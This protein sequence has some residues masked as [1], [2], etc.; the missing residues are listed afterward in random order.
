[1]WFIDVGMHHVISHGLSF[2]L[3]QHVIHPL[4]SLHLVG[5]HEDVGNEVETGGFPLLPAT[6]E[7]AQIDQFCR[8]VK[9]VLP[10]SVVHLECLQV[11]EITF[12]IRQLNSALILC[13][14][15]H[16]IIVTNSW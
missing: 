5:I 12:H 15:K 2:L 13:V 1:M 7:V 4:L 3:T 8:Q 10:L 9:L 11:D 16:I 6:G 14:G